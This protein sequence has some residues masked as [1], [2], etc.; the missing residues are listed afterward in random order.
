METTVGRARG[1]LFEPRATFKEVE[2]EFTKPGVIWGRY[3]LPLAL[4]GPLAGAV[5]RLLFGK[6]IAKRACPSPSR[7]AARLPGLASRWCCSW[8][9]CSR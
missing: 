5:G 7:S 8:P 3:I 2:S 9:R 6:R 4:I 1:V